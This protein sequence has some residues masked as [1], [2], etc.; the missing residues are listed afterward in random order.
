[1]YSLIMWKLG[2]SGH[3]RHVSL[4]WRM[5]ATGLVGRSHLLAP[6][7]DIPIMYPAKNG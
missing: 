6:R 2:K 4:L 7:V 5:H 1:M 3:E